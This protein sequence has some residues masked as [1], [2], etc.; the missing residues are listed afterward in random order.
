M[1]IEIHC[2]YND[3]EYTRFIL[4]VPNKDI[5]QKTV[6]LQNMTTIQTIKIHHFP[7]LAERPVIWVG[8]GAHGAHPPFDRSPGTP[9]TKP[10]VRVSV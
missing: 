2:M 6:H 4:Q 3:I 7:V 8:V 5:K 9:P 10:G 1:I